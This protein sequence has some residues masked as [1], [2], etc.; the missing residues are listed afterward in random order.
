MSSRIDKEPLTLTHNSYCGF[1]YNLARLQS[2]ILWK[3]F[4]WAEEGTIEDCLGMCQETLVPYLLRESIINHTKLNQY[5]NIQQNPI[6]NPMMSPFCTG[7]F[8]SFIWP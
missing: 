8:A 3:A 5:V 1:C 4:S 6:C 7:I 2:E